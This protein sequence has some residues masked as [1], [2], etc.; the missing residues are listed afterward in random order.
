MR[1]VGTLVGLLLAS[2]WCTTARTGGWHHRP[3]RGL[4]FFGM[5]LAGPGNVA[6]TSVF[7]AGLVVVLL[8]L[9][10]L[11]AHTTVVDRVGGH[12]WSG[13][14]ARR[15]WS[16]HWRWP[17][18]NGGLPAR[19]GDL[20]VRL[21]RYLRGS[22]SQ[23]RPRPL[24]HA[25]SA[26]R[27]ARS[28]AQASVDRARAEPVPGA[29]EVEL[30]AA[31]LAHTHRLR[32]RDAGRRGVATALREAGGLPSL[33]ELLASSAAVLESCERS[34]RTGRAP[35]MQPGLRGVQE[36]FLEAVRTDPRSAQRHLRRSSR[37]VT[38]SRTAWTR[39][40]T[41]CAARPATAA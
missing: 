28:N 8:S 24:Q 6:W 40:S 33:A 13:G 20:L 36:T 34:V 4:L 41:S 15:R 9:A 30:G 31:V 26:A 19:L 22:R 7:L 27:L 29:N 12:R 21:P 23:L 5:R 1:V 35:E 39:C 17:A 11:P 32:A 2:W 14:V 3:D 10:G 38:E 37:R 16:R 25:R 18:G